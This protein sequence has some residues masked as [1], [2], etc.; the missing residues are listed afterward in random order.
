MLSK[1]RKLQLLKDKNH[2]LEQQCELLKQSYSA[3]AELFHD[4]N[5]HLQVIYHM[6]VQSGNEEL[7]TYISHITAPVQT[8]ANSIWTGVDIVDAILNYKK[9]IANQKGYHM[10]INAELPNNT[11][12]ES[13]DYCTVLSNLIDNAI[14]AL[15]RFP[16]PTDSLFIQISIRRI[17]QFLMIQ[18][19]NPC[20][21]SPEK[22]YG[23]FITSKSN[24]RQH[25]LGLQNVSKIVKKYQG[26][27]D[28]EVNN[29]VFTVTAL[30]FFPLNQ[31]IKNSN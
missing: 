22:K 31:N 21:D 16:K 19:S 6:A 2:L 25:G 15:D 30:L 3:N 24:K 18:V 5:H 9:T 7:Q 4:M 23:R 1:S 12:I 11:G 8:L 13:D 20:F 17:H 29:R 10:D 14:E 26:S 28:F 27:L